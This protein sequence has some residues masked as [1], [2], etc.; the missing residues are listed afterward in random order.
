MSLLRR[1]V[2]H[3]PKRYL[4]GLLLAAAL[5]FL[6]LCL[7]G[8]DRLFYYVDAIE[9]AGAA[10][11]F[12]GLLQL[13]AYFGAFDTFGYAF[14]G[15]RRKE[16]SYQDLMAYNTQKQEKRRQQE[17]PFM[18]FILVGILFMLIGFLLGLGLPRP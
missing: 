2:L 12:M 17:L 18:P 4:A 10:V 11:F 15:F 7:R 6:G 13:V 9:L 5:S 14:S 8:F 16:R 3:S 1:L